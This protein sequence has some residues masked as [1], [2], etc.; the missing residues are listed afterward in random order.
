MKPE[1]MW[2]KKQFEDAP[3]AKT[4]TYVRK[5]RAYCA[6]DAERDIAMLF[7]SVDDFHR[8]LAGERKHIYQD[9]DAQKH[10][11][12]VQWQGSDF[13]MGSSE[14]Y[15]IP[16]VLKERIEKP[17]VD[18]PDGLYRMEP[19]DDGLELH[20]MDVSSD[21]YLDVREV[22]QQIYHRFQEFVANREAYAREGVRHKEGVLLYGPQGNGKTREIV[23]ILENSKADG[24]ISIFIPSTIDHLEM[25]QPFR[26]PLKSKTVV[27]VLEEL[28]QRTDEDRFED[29]LSF[30]DG[31]MSWDHSFIIATT[32][33][34]E[35]LPRNVV[36][37]PG[38]F[39]L[40][41]EFA[42][43]NKSERLRYLLGRGVPAE[44]A[45]LAAELSKDLS[46][47]YLAQSVTQSRIKG[48]PIMSYLKQQKT[49]RG[50]VVE[51]FK[52]PM[53]FCRTKKRD[54]DCW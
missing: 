6:T 47:D 20:P 40:V 10:I 42:N 28:T 2:V 46:L 45:E 8:F 11:L 17:E 44:D 15:G 18:I 4:V 41:L 3:I 34:P 31:E 9:F 5:K 25:L 12:E 43:P 54:N 37:R 7:V 38:R 13:T 22:S 30:L 1:L 27:F 21:R 26:E 23:R 39:D 51:S 33:Y 50:K 19:A 14:K 32:N 16:L 49:L 48:I 52:E 29:L 36:D 35:D 24:V 53:G